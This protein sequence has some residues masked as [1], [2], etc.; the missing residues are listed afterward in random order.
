MESKR[1]DGGA[2]GASAAP[3]SAAGVAA[4]VIEYLSQSKQSGEQPA[5]EKKEKA[6]KYLPPSTVQRYATVLWQTEAHFRQA[7]PPI[8]AA[9][10]EIVTNRQVSKKFQLSSEF[11]DNR[12][13]LVL[14]SLDQLR[15][16]FGIMGLKLM[17]SAEFIRQQVR[18]GM[19]VAETQQ[20][21]AEDA[22]AEQKD[23]DE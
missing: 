8:A 20:L 5:E 19:S 2:A 18:V 4:E 22:A 6:H 16:S 15:A 7:I 23:D 1:A 13:P 11:M 17:Q 10:L 14:V 12:A 3:A 21:D 9:V